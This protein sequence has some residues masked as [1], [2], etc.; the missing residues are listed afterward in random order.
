VEVHEHLLHA[1]AA[2]PMRL[3]TAWQSDALWSEAI[4]FGV[5]EICRCCRYV[6]VAVLG[7]VEVPELGAEHGEH[8]IFEVC[9]RAI[10]AFEGRCDGASGR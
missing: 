8:D 9:I 6:H 3:G 1:G 5:L 4:V 10:G 2:E 7:E